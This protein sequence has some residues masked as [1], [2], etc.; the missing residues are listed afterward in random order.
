[1]CQVN[2]SGEIRERIIKEINMNPNHL[3]DSLFDEAVD[4]LT[5]DMYHNSFAQ[6]YLIAPD[7][8]KERV[9]HNV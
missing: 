3:P 7:S 6:F 1:M 4:A 5:Q 2:I 9:L 8:E